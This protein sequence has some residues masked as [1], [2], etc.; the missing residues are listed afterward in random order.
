MLNYC[1]NQQTVDFLDPLHRQDRMLPM[2]IKGATI[3]LYRLFH[4]QFE[5]VIRIK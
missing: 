1:Y 3:T 2:T 5:A 4:I